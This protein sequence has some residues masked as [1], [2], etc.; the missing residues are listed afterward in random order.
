MAAF[1]ARASLDFVRHGIAAIAGLLPAEITLT[2][3][4]SPVD[5]SIPVG[6]F[7][8]EKNLSV[9][10]PQISVNILTTASTP[11][12]LARVPRSY[13]VFELRQK[14]Y[15]EQDLKKRNV[16]F[17]AIRFVFMGTI[18]DDESYIGHLGIVNG[19]F[20]NCVILSQ[21][22][23]RLRF[24]ALD[25]SQ[26]IVEAPSA[27]GITLAQLADCLSSD[28]TAIDFEV[29][30][31]R[32]ARSTMIDSYMWD[33]SVP[34]N[35]VPREFELPLRFEGEILKF[36]ILATA[37][38]LDVKTAVTARLPKLTNFMITFRRSLRLDSAR[39]LDFNPE[40]DPC[41]IARIPDH[42]AR[43]KF[44][45]KADVIA[46]ELLTS[47]TISQALKQLALK[48]GVAEGAID[49]SVDGKPCAGGDVLDPNLKYVVECH[50]L[51]SLAVLL[52][53]DCGR[54]PLEPVT[55]TF[56]AL[57]NPTVDAL[58]QKLTPSV[59]SAG[60]DLMYAKRPLVPTEFLTTIPEAAV[61][62]C[63]YLTAEGASDVKFVD[64]A[65]TTISL[66]V[67]PDLTV[68]GLKS[69]L[70]RRFKRTKALPRTLLLSFWDQFLSDALK[71]ADFKLPNNCV[72]QVRENPNACEVV[73]SGFGIGPS[74]VRYRASDADRVSDL[75]TFLANEENLTGFRIR[76]A[77]DGS[78]LLH[79]LA[80][81]E[82]I[83][84]ANELRFVRN[85]V[86]TLIQLE[87]DSCLADARDSLR[88]SLSLPPGD[89]IVFDV[90]EFAPIDRL[91][92]PVSYRIKS[93]T[94]KR[95]VPFSYDGRTVNLNV[96]PQSTL[97]EVSAEVAAAFALGKSPLAF[98]IDDDF[99]EDDARICD[100]GDSSAVIEVRIRGAMM[101]TRTAAPS[102][103]KAPQE[104]PP[105][106]PANLGGAQ[107]QLGPP[108]KP[109]APGGKATPAA[110]N[111]VRVWLGP[112][113]TRMKYEPGMV[114]GDLTDQIRDWK[115]IS[116][117][118]EIRFEYVT[119]LG[120]PVELDEDESLG[121]YDW[122]EGDLNVVVGEPD[123][124]LSM[125][126]N[127]LM[128][129]CRLP[130]S[131]LTRIP[132]NFVQVG[133][134]KK[135][136]LGLRAD[137]T[138]LVAREQ[139]GKKLDADPDDVILTLG[140]RPLLDHWVLNRLK[141]GEKVIAVEVEDRREL[142]MTT[143]MLRKT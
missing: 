106:I 85:G 125:S 63:V 120:D 73:V 69:E 64:Q 7:S 122:T 55:V 95:A 130:S 139:V 59:G 27:K 119:E 83:P 45:H 70:L 5:L 75:E 137:A 140:G 104:A 58:L 11:T 128:M 51:L 102:R 86:E 78:T 42:T 34:I 66:S 72:I 14:Y 82:V 35:V 97:A 143:A 26:P 22:C 12:V 76:C 71:F 81:L 99:L 3:D 24:T 121:G 117:D 77:G 89:E 2:V 4:G 92:Q 39:I 9:Q 116:D 57:S 142:L 17:G 47:T 31:K 115:S 36:P 110:G 50:K 84:L 37:T 48:L 90:D 21:G 10:V 44:T 96:N 20:L 87:P 38:I 134:N 60:F 74:P 65:G 68:L 141:I 118:S 129:T 18:L 79:D 40:L 133:S 54:S 67:E 105:R 88:A 33:P 53:S 6:S 15:T 13:R 41:E 112:A 1:P 127:E 108:G 98:V 49:V 46:L 56:D 126:M 25:G 109:A 80:E 29:D 61:L 30:A 19:A 100:V 123:D 93:A 111:F 131:Q 91:A 101:R 43:F 124:G 107:P 135:F 136:Q 113:T 132:Y 32:L 114:V 103:P 23:V 28:P 52:Y 94:S 62:W 16:S 8:P 138:V